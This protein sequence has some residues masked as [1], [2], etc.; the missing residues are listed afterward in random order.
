MW[1]KISQTMEQPTWLIILKNPLKSW[2]IQWDLLLGEHSWL[3]YFL[4]ILV[5]PMTSLIRLSTILMKFWRKIMTKIMATNHNKNL[6]KLMSN[7]MNSFRRKSFPKK[8]SIS[9]N[10][11]HRC[12]KPRTYLPY[13]KQR[14]I[15]SMV[16][17]ARSIMPLNL[18]LIK[19]LRLNHHFY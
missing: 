5:I 11:R 9:K 14:E 1:L 10:T 12:L 17:R 3:R 8:N 2:M 13:W 16:M 15:E 7:Q 6:C 4:T 18:V 19:L